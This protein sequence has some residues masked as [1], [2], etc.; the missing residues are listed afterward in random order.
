MQKINP[1]Q[2][3]T[4]SLEDKYRQLVCELNAVLLDLRDEEQDALQRGNQGVYSGLA[5]ARVAVEVAMDKGCA[6]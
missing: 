4:L 1:T 3:A 2:G 5:F 6:V